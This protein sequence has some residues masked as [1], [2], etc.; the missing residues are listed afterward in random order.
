MPPFRRFVIAACSVFIASLVASTA[1]TQARADNVVL[2]TQAQLQALGASDFEIAFATTDRS[3]ATYTDISNYNSFVSSE[4]GQNQ[5]LANL[6]VT[7][8]AVVSTS[9]SIASVNA[10]NDGSIPVFNTR[11]MLVAYLGTGLY[12]GSLINPIEYDQAGDLKATGRSSGRVGSP[13]VH[14]VQQTRRSVLLCPRSGLYQTPTLAGCRMG[15]CLLPGAKRQTCTAS[16]PSPRRSHLLRR[17]LLPNPPSS[18]LVL[19]LA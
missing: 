17:P 9:A 10:P 18:S 8:N 3:L 6:G 19:A 11:G 12:S 13:T 2:P 14:S 4:A 1:T 7:W 15:R 16:M 5:T